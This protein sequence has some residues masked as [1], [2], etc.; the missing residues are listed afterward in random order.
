[1]FKISK[2]V[3]YSLLAIRYI[4]RNSITDGNI[5]AKKISAEENIPFELLAKLLQKMAKNGIIQSVQGTKGGYKL[6]EDLNKLTL[7]QLINA[8][9]QNIQLTDCSFEGATKENC[10]R[11]ED[12]CLRNPLTNLQNKI[13]DIMSQTKVSEII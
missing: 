7:L 3:E 5:N 2:S 10:G 9:E 4:S 11:I 6:I 12:C 13:N 1:M 8:I